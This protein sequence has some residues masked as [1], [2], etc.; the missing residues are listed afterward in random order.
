MTVE[1]P[2]E[3]AD[4]SH[5]VAAWVSATVPDMSLPPALA[6]VAEHPAEEEAAAALP[7]RA[8]SVVDSDDVDPDTVEVS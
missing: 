5:R 6:A 2:A 4:G 8:P 3:E 7:D 1:D